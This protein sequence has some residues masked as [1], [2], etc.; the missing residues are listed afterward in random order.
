MIVIVSCMSSPALKSACQVVLRSNFKA[1]LTSGCVQSPGMCAVQVT[2]Y[3]QRFNL[4]QSLAFSITRFSAWV[5]SAILLALLLATLPHQTSAAGGL[6]SIS[7]TFAAGRATLLVVALVA[8]TALLASIPLAGNAARSARRTDQQLARQSSTTGVGRSDKS[9]PA[10]ATPDPH[11]A[12]QQSKA[13]SSATDKQESETLQAV[14]DA[15]QAADTKA[16]IPSTEVDSGEQLGDRAPSTTDRLEGD[17]L[18]GPWE[19]GNEKQGPG[20]SGKR[21][22]FFRDI[23]TDSLPCSGSRFR[24]RQ[25]WHSL[26]RSSV[27]KLRQRHSVDHAVICQTFR[28]SLPAAWL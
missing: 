26:R 5:S 21:Q 23:S 6:L 20:G 11:G 10:F 7:H 18:R 2:K 15:L 4:S 12:S 8:V 1:K 24:Q 17:S 16:Q 19:P 28:H 13:P 25:R 22:N 9:A 3:V 27:Y 14:D